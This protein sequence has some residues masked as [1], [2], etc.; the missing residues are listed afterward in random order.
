MHI[1]FTNTVAGAGPHNAV[2]FAVGQYR[3]GSTVNVGS[4]LF[5][6]ASGAIVTIDVPI[7]DGVSQFD[8][9]VTSG[10]ASNTNTF[11]VQLDVSCQQTPVGTPLP[12]A[13]PLSG[14]DNATLQ[15]ILTLVTLIQRQVAPF[16]Y[17]TRATH[18]GLT[19]HGELSVQGLIG[20]KVIITDAIAGTIGTELGD[21]EVDFGLG[22]INW[23]NPDGWL[24]RQF[25][26]HVDNLSYPANAGAHTRIGYSLAPGVV[27]T[28]VELTREL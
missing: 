9:S 22:W 16:A 25:L 7:I 1:A 24:P 23:G 3:A 13:P 28:L 19:G 15:S 18:S 8:V 14:I 10:P 4:G 11:S 27:A 17:V 5:T 2:Q 20:C 21:P 6:V 12:P 26:G